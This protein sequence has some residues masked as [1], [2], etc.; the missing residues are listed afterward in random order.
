VELLFP[1]GAT[2]EAR[3]QDK[4]LDSWGSDAIHS[5]CLLAIDLGPSVGTGAIDICTIIGM[6]HL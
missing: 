1:N 6:G 3:G 5:K 2:G 4:S